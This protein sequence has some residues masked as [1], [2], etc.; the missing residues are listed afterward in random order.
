MMPASVVYPLLRRRRP[1]PRARHGRTHKWPIDLCA[2]RC[3]LGAASWESRALKYPFAAIG[4]NVAQW[5]RWCQRRRRQWRRRRRRRR[6]CGRAG[7]R[8][9]ARAIA[10]GGE[11]R[12]ARPRATDEQLVGGGQGVCG[13]PSRKECMRYPAR[14]ESGDRRALERRRHTQ[15]A[16]AGSTADWGQGTGGSAP[17]TLIACL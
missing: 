14:C 16:G 4:R 13:L 3:V 6:E 9:P 11:G 5:H 7:P 17:R 15:R 12:G 1:T 10:S 8:S 2:R